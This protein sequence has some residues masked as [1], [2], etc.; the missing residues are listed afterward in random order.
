VADRRNVPPR[1]QIEALA[2]HRFA[3]GEYTVAHWENFLLTECTGATLMP[4]GMVHP[5]VLF[6]LPIVGAG[7]SITD[8]FALGQ[9]ESDL[10]IM[11]ESY[12]W[13][14]LAP[15]REEQ[16]YRVEGS[17]QSSERCHTDS[18]DI[19]DRIQFRFEIFS[20]DRSPVARSIITWHYT[21]G[22]L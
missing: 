11:I 14:F 12:D 8:M 22:M 16:A 6:H 10:S 17:I 13:E 5:I 3:G 2:G 7:T 1:E 9:A 18:D 15:L 21:R 19:Y 4:D 20:A